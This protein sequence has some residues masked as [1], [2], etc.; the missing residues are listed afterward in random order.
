MSRTFKKKTDPESAETQGAEIRGEEASEQLKMNSLYRGVVQGVDPI[1]LSYTVKVDDRDS[2]VDN[3][4]WAAGIFSH[5][6][7]MQTSFIPTVGTGVIILYGDESMII[8]SY[9]TTPAD[10]NSS[11]FKTHTGTGKLKKD[12]SAY[13]KDF[14][15]KG[16]RAAP[17]ATIPGDMLEGEFDIG[18]TTGCGIAF[19]TNLV[20]MRAS[21]RAKVETH[22]LNDMVRIVSET[23]RHHSSFGDFEVYNDGR[24]NCRVN[25]TSYEHEAWG[26]LEP[27]DAKVK[28]KQEYADLKDIDRIKETGRWRFSNYLGF[29]GDFL[30]QIITDPTV[31]IG[32][33]ATEA[34]RSGKSRMQFMN[35]GS[36]LAQSVGDIVL[37][38]V[39]RIVAPIEKNRS[40][41]PAGNTYEDF[42]KLESK[43]LKIWEYG[44]DLEDMSKTCYQ[45]R[46]YARYLSGFHAYARFLQLD[47]DWDVPTEAESPIP[48]W[49][50]K[51][52]DRE[53]V[54]T[55]PNNIDV[56]S[57]I[58]IMRD[59]SQ[60]F[61]DGYGSAVVMSRGIIQ[62][63][64]SKHI[65]LEA[66]GNINIRAGQDVNITARR[67]IDI[68]SV[69]GGVIIKSRTWL[70]GLCEWGSIW[71]KSDADTK[72]GATPPELGDATQDPA[73]EILTHGIVLDAPNSGILCETDHQV[74]FN[75]RG[76]E[77]AEKGAFIVKNA[78][79]DVMVDARKDVVVKTLGDIKT[80]S[81]NFNVISRKTNIGA[82]QFNVVGRE[83][84]PFLHVRSGLT[85]MQR[86]R[87]ESVDATHYLYGPEFKYNH[88]S[89][90]G[91]A[92]ESPGNMVFTTPGQEVFESV[93][94]ADFVAWEGED[95]DL[96][97]PEQESGWKLREAA[98]Y[99]WD[100]DYE[101]FESLAQQTIRQLNPADEHYLDPDAYGDWNVGG[102]VLK[103][104]LRTEISTPWPGESAQHFTHTAGD[105]L[106]KPLEKHY[107]NLSNKPTPLQ[108]QSAS[109]KYLKK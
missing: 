79:G 28:T 1:N 16:S 63:S 77:E 80:K 5:M 100:V 71:L 9:P 74:M 95:V 109:W 20:K 7:G 6:F 65:E 82:N 101:F 14:V 50:S 38:R 94:V 102:M 78:G 41:D 91:N 44:A 72:T 45:L 84:V 43:Y 34:A 98:D 106:Y 17:G 88:Y 37:E 107:K 47:K 57:S 29:L 19:L 30:H 8:G 70:K 15:N 59:G 18:H 85:E 55:G 10:L 69:V 23:Y 53:A 22:L 108:Q 42:E 26:R 64:A 97:V 58:R 75:L 21:D 51:E 40:D 2:V 49:S 61:M 31:V 104:G 86:V 96:E 103:A 87:A 11:S 68:V 4:M 81:N 27:S 62:I 46:E 66:P 24:L 89:S 33:Y 73:P 35:D 54:H 93:D 92:S 25:G 3:C 60:V 105:A 83:G 39:T 48:E 56:Y 32:K 90:F 76:Y 36:I 99:R 12:I 13:T 52:K 67:N